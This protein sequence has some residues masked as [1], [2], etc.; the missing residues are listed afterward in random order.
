[1]ATLHVMYRVGENWVNHQTISTSE[2]TSNLGI[3][4]F[5]VCVSKIPSAVLSLG[6]SLHTKL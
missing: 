6:L 4:G 2:A 3:L 1:M 5:Y